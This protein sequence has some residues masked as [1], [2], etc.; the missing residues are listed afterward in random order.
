MTISWTNFDDSILP[1]RPVKGRGSVSNRSG[2]FEGE[3]RA[4]IDDGWLL[5]EDLSDR[6][7]LRT[8]L[9]IDAARSVITRNT[10]P[11]VPFDRS[12]NPYRGCEHG[13]VYCF[14]RP[15]HAYLGLSPG[16]DFETKLFWKPDAAA[17]LT[18][19]L[20]KP[21]YRCAPIA[22]GTN[23]D[24]YQP[25]E[26]E[27]LA[28]RG[29]LQ[30]LRDCAH[31]F[32]IVTKNALVC[33][34]LDLIA[35]AGLVNQTRVMLSITTLDRSL[36]NKMEPRAST[37]EK[38]L[39]AI[40]RLSDAGVPTGVLVAPIIPAVNDH[41]IEEILS[42]A[43]EAGATSAGHVLLRLPLE[44]ADLFKEWLATH[45]PDRSERVLSLIRQSR[46]GQLY[47]SKFG[48]RM[49]G[50]GPYA[51]MIATRMKLARK[52]FSLDRRTLDTMDCSAFTPPRKPSSQLSLF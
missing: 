42:R 23:T 7:R 37:P 40:R 51:D 17:L 1:D 9:G 36:A 2:R 31:P 12:I 46:G 19:E 18:A 20:A 33:R 49:R 47:R 41:E 15:T 16:L 3:Q 22:F 44:I 21:K 48:E 28:T 38:R 24:P 11:D 52:R 45:M 34:D 29:L 32:S 43:A 4:R 27:T 10:S 6:P 25:V 8:Q 13:C 26:R 39:E 5:E 30:V 14:A 35:P 50:T